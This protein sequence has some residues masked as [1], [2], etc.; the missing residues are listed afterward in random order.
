MQ[1]SENYRD[2]GSF[3]VI[4]YGTNHKAICIF[5][6]VINTAISWISPCGEKGGG[7]IAKVRHRKR[8]PSLS[9]TIDRLR[10]FRVRVWVSVRITLPAEVRSLQQSRADL[11][12]G[13]PL[14]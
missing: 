4:H 6:L 11:C 10:W 1:A 12:D 13:R 3:N 9:D 5:L 2:S 14:L 8:L 7:A